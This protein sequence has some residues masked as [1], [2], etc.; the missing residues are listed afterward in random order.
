MGRYK[1]FLIINFA[2][3]GNLFKGREEAE[4]DP[5]FENFPTSLNVDEGSPVKIDCKLVGTQPIAVKW[6]KDN[7]QLAESDRI[8]FAS[9]PEN[10]VY[11][12]V[13]PTV[14]STDNGQYHASASNANGEVIAAFCLIV[15]YDA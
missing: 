6:F 9:Q 4:L 13:I 7:N 14:L 11:S 15:S 5:K 12:L 1:L 2:T 10:G 8:S 3:I